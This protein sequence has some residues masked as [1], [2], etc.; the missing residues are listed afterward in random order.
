MMNKIETKWC[1]VI[2]TILIVQPKVHPEITTG[3]QMY[4]S[5]IPFPSCALWPSQLWE[6]PMHV[7]MW[8]IN[9]VL[10]ARAPAG[11]VDPAH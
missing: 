3:H 6:Q 1:M 11:F 9:Y 5:A 7:H 4:I 2:K 8:P 10:T